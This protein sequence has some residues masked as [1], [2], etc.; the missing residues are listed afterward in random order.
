MMSFRAGIVTKID[1]IYSYFYV[2]KIYGKEKS[3][4]I[5]ELNEELP[6]IG[7]DVYR[8]IYEYLV[9]NHSD[10]IYTP[11]HLE[12]DLKI[13]LNPLIQAVPPIE[14]GIELFERK[15]ASFLSIL[16]VGWIA[17]LCKLDEFEIDTSGRPDYVVRGMKAEA[18][19]GLLLKA[20]ELSEIRRQ[21]FEA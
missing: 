16:N 11:D 2:N 1:D 19:H 17:L 21:W 18:L 7:N 20:V 6:N 13:F 10:L 14:S 12:N 4:I 9:R 15:P 5:A 8:G 3:A